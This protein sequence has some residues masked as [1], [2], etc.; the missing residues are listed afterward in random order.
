[1]YH[2]SLREDAPRAQRDPKTAFQERVMARHGEFPV[3]T[4]TDDTGVEGDETRFTVEV[5]VQGEPIAT[6]A[7]RTKRAAEQ[8]AAGR[9]LEREEVQR[10]A[11]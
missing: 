3:Y 8:E 1:V 10:G 2:D 6:G 9:A 11:D 4:L 7:G 5:R